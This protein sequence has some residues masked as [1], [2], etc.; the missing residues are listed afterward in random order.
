MRNFLVFVGSLASI[1]AALFAPGCTDT[2]GSVSQTPA[3][4]ASAA[5][6]SVASTCTPPT[7]EGTTHAAVAADETWTAASSPHVVDTSL[8]IAA[9]RTVTVEPCAVVR[10]KSGAAFVV[11]GKL[12]AEGAADRPIRFERGDS[13]SPWK[14]IEARKGAELR[15]AY[16]T[17]EGG[18]SDDGATLDIR[19]DQDVATQPIFF[20]DHV[21]V[22]DSGSLGV[23]VREGGGFAPGSQELTVT[24]SATF[25]I[26]IWGRAAGTLPSGTYTGNAIDE[27]VLPAIGGRDDVKEDTTLANRGVPY[28]IGGNDGG[29]SFAIAGAASAPLLTIEPGV[30][31]R[32]EKEARLLVDSNGSSPA[33]ALRAVGTAEKPIVFESAADVPAAGDWVGIVVEGTPDPRTTI[34]HAK[35]SHAGGASQISSYGCPSPGTSSFANEGAILFI[36]GEPASA[37]VT[38][39]A[40]TD[41]AGEGIVRG[42]TGTPVDFLPTN[43]FTNVAR[44]NQTFPKP[45]ADVCPEPA[46]CPK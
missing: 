16:V 35:V 36:G 29:K 38:S 2:S 1:G 19:G 12:S 14:T 26:S 9:D 20:V 22:K 5:D 43:T 24:G 34:T 30:T 45:S 33:G 40:I 42:W 39:T 4:D 23:L 6:T 21:T 44:C 11:E 17:I 3:A 8:A 46:P 32:F 37:V 31:L 27:I 13:A 10:M 15:F 7:G 18:G 25:P 28:R 41:S